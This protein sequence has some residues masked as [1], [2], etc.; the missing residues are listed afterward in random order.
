MAARCPKPFSDS[1]LPEGGDQELD[2]QREEWSKCFLLMMHKTDRKG[3][4]VPSLLGKGEKTP[5]AF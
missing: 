1:K 3:C 4:D 2:G 5:E